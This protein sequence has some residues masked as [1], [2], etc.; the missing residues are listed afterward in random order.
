[1][2]IYERSLHT[3]KNVFQSLY[4]DDG[5]LTP[6]EVETLDQLFKMFVN[7]KPHLNNSTRIIYI[8]L[9][10]EEC[11][12][13]VQKRINENQSANI[14]SDKGIT[15]ED[16]EKIDKKYTEV[17]NTYNNKKLLILDGSLDQL[18]LARHAANFLIK[19][20]SSSK[21]TTGMVFRCPKEIKLDELD[22][23]KTEH[24]DIKVLSNNIE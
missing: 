22:N 20:P 16:L 19:S 2:S 21:P 9:S 14:E 13:R 1:M 24:D 18:T 17:L 7:F 4:S 3:A 8:H 23:K 12:D 5:S 15:K 10:P 11:F 6:S